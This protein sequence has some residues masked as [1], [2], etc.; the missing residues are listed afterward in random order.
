MMTNAARLVALA[1]LVAACKAP[2]SARAT[3]TPDSSAAKPTAETNPVNDPMVAHADS[4]RIRGSSLAKV[5]LIV[6]SDF[7]CPYCKM[8]HD[9]SD[10]TIR[11][12]YVDNGKVRLAYIN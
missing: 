11:R 7:Q 9:S 8:W 2:E 10:A 5:W 12:D 1:A 3:T 6:A 4:A